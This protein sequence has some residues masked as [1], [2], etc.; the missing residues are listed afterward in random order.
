M[1]GG[2]RLIFCH[3]D[4]SHALHLVRK[5]ETDIEREV[6]VEVDGNGGKVDEEVAKVGSW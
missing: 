5:R 1:Q 4:W 3:E 6:V 2:R